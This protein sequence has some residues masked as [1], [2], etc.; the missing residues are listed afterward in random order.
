MSVSVVHPSACGLIRV[1]SAP[2][3]HRARRLLVALAC[4]WASIAGA[5][6]TAPA[7]AAAATEPV[8]KFRSPE[9]GWIDFSS[10]LDESYGFLP[11]AMPITE[12]AIGY[13]AGGGLMFL[14][15][16][17]GKAAAEFQ[18]PNISGVFGF[19]TENGTWGGGAGDIRNWM[20]GRL[21][22]VA[23]AFTASVNLDFY[24]LGEDPALADHPLRYTLEPLGGV[25]QGKYQLGDSRFFAGLGYVYVGMDTSF[26]AP[27]GAPGLPDHA[28]ESTL[29][30]L[31][32]SLSYDTRDNVFTPTT[33]LY[34]EASLA[35]FSEALGA[36]GEYQRGTLL[37]MYYRPLA[38]N[39]FLGVKGQATAT[40]SDPP[41]YL[42][43]YVQLR[44][45]PAMR[46]QGEQVAQ[47][48]AE[49]RWQFY[50]RWSLVGFAG[51]G[52]AQAE[53]Q[54]EERDRS[55]VTGGTGFRYELARKYGIH[56]GAD[57]AWGP[58]ETALYLQVG[59][60]WMR[61]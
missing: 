23:A 50:K 52:L 48:E 39:L 4:T 19:G 30:A 61:P 58:D 57:I 11:I 1:A 29:G 47:A 3:V 9:D 43:P 42:Q 12:P 20:D 16:P 31:L 59:S 56:A 14:D 40:W 33:G 26:E 15:E 8:S 37:A 45:A 51:A 25:I 32:P 34:V 21:Q 22:T 44:G 10:F 55:V 7:P 18:R 54:G 49:L 2:V 38:R 17:M 13:G 41:F 60:A 24:G 6:S 36:D 53:I 5:Q 28:S 27:P 46:Y 35:A